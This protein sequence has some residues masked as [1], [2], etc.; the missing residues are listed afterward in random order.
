MAFGSDWT[1]APLD[2]LLGLDAALTRR[3]I[4]GANPEGWVPEQR[5]DLEEALLAYTRNG[6]FAGFSD[7]FTGTLSPGR[8]ADL[9]VLSGDLFAQPVD[10]ITELEVDM[11]WVQG[12]EVY[13]RPGVR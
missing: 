9:V 12:Q 10:R 2:P 6:A 4:D 1:V 7:G 13:T 3:T 5:I 11:T 8:M